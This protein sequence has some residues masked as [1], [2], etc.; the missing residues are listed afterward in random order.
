MKNESTAWKDWAEF[1]L[2]LLRAGC[3]IA[4]LADWLPPVGQW[5]Q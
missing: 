3:C 2:L 5:L 1:T 4:V